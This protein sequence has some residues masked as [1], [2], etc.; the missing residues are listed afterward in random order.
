MRTPATVI[1]E[2]ILKAAQSLAAAGEDPSPRRIA[3]A[4]GISLRNT[5]YHRLKLICHGQWPTAEPEDTIAAR[6][7]R[8]DDVL[9]AAKTLVAAGKIPSWYRISLLIRASRFTISDCRRYWVDQGLWPADPVQK[10]PKTKP[11]VRKPELLRQPQPHPSRAC[12][13]SEEEIAVLTAEIRKER[14]DSQ[15]E[16]TK[17]L[18]PSRTWEELHAVNVWDRFRLK[19]R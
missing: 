16:Y 1:R 15:R 11:R 4:S 8:R 3:E 17:T 2:A 12:D 10:P 18:S 6:M 13:S 5:Y 9:A 19:F 14:G 7:D